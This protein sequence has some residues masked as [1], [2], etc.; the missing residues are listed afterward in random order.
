VIQFSGPHD[1]SAQAHFIAPL[2]HVEMRY[3]DALG[4][5]RAVD[6]DEAQAEARRGV[7]APSQDPPVDDSFPRAS[8]HRNGTPYRPAVP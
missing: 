1:P 8:A 7:D 2:G 3:D 6:G 5:A 4:R